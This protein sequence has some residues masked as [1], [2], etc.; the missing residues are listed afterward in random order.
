MC[1]KITWHTIISVSFE[2]CDANGSGKIDQDD[3]EQVLTSI[4]DTASY[5]GDPVLKR[6]QIKVGRERGGEK[7]RG[8][9]RGVKAMNGL[10]WGVHRPSFIGGRRYLTINSTSYAFG[11]VP[12]IC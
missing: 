6:A 4:N 1:I 9:E 12:Y 8:M 11:C 7:E 5:F 2:L 10:W 3:M